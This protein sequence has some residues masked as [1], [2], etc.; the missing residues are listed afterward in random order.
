MTSSTILSGPCKLVFDGA[1]IYS[2]GNVEVK[3]IEERFDIKVDGVRMMQQRAKDRRYEITLTPAGEFKDLAVL[4]PYASTVIGTKIFANDTLTLWSRDATANKRIF[5]NVAITKLPPIR[6]SS[7]Q[8]M[9]GSMT[10]TAILKDGAVPGDADAYV[11]QSDDT[12]P[13]EALDVSKI[14]TPIFARSWG[15]SPWDAFFVGPDGM[16][17]DFP[18][19]LKPHTVDGLGTVNYSVISHEGTCNFTPMG[20]TEEQIR[21]AVGANA[22]LGSAP[23]VNN[24]IAA[25]T[26][27]HLTL[28]SAQMQEA[29]FTF[30]ADAERLGPLTA[31]ATQTLSA[32]ALNPIYRIAAAAP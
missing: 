16:E 3:L 24:L 20:L 12:W 7:G 5:S 28:Y 17:F 4:W 19:G 26:G 23:T 30:G 22:V 1:T 8:T 9:L 27:C 11:V 10:F 14:I 32:G 6:A 13:S 29:A 25:G 2:Q 18:L 15:S 21:S 31:K